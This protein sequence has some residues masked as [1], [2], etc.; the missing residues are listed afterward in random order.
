MLIIRHENPFWSWPIARDKMSEP[1]SSIVQIKV[2]RLKC[3]IMPQDP[4]KL[5][6]CD[7]PYNRFGARDETQ[8]AHL[9]RKTVFAFQVQMRDVPMESPVTIPDRTLKGR[10]G[11]PTWFRPGLLLGLV[12]SKGLLTAAAVSQTPTPQPVMTVPPTPAPVYHGQTGAPAMT[13]TLLPAD[14]GAGMPFP[15]TGNGFEPKVITPG[16]PRQGLVPPPPAPALGGPRVIPVEPL[17]HQGPALEPT[18]PKVI[19]LQRDATGLVPSRPPDAPP[20]RPNS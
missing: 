9:P 20:R 14:E 15:F 13:P 11:P 10:P 5:A 18:R 6:N 8:L 17:P 19:Q 3:R 7:I 1:R 12:L 4:S 2:R 16:P